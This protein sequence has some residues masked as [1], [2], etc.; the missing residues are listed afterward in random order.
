MA[1]KIKQIQTKFKATQE[2]DGS[3]T[4]N[5]GDIQSEE[6]RDIVLN[7]ELGP[8][9]ETDS[10]EIASLHLSYF[11]VISSRQVDL[12]SK[13]AIARPVT[14][15][16]S[17]VKGNKKID[18]AKNRVFTADTIANAKLLGDQKKLQ[19]GRDLVNKAITQ[20]Q[21]SL[22]AS[23]TYTQGLVDDLKRTLE[24]LK[25][26]VAYEDHGYQSMS[27]MSAQHYNQRSAGTMA[28]KSYETSSRM[29]S[30]SAYKQ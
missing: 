10:Q 8:S 18:L 22:T 6:D 30:K 23:D 9:A 7:I 3:H 4:I 14:V 2:A 13:V 17:A 26:V 5:I 16:E 29:Q 11:N 12:T 21:G 24:G 25:D 27:A 19:E 28:N 20:L 15:V 1:F